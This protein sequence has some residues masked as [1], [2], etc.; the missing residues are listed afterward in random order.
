M[1][2]A[3]IYILGTILTYF[4]AI[5]VGTG[6]GLFTE[7]RFDRESFYYFFGGVSVFVFIALG[8][9][10]HQKMVKQLYPKTFIFSFVVA[11]FSFVVWFIFSIYNLNE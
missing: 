5:G 8:F 2:L 4:G 6:I 1:L 10:L 3:P 11:T 9:L 7:A